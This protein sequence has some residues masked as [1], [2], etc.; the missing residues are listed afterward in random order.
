MLRLKQRVKQE[1]RVAEIRSRKGTGRLKETELPTHGR[2]KDVG[3][4]SLVPNLSGSQSRRERTL[5]KSARKCEMVEGVNRHCSSPWVPVVGKTGIPLMPTRVRRA[6]QLVQKGKAVVG[7]KA[8]IF[9]LRLKEREDGEVQLVGMGIDT[10]SKREGFTVMSAKHTFLNILSDAVTDVKE[11]VETR[12]IMRRARR[13]RKTPCRQNR[14]NRSRGGI[15]P[16][17]YARCNAKLR[18]R[19]IIASLFPIQICVVEDI[20]AKTM[21][22][23]K[24]W[25]KSFSPMEVGKKWFYGELTKMGTL[26]L[27]QGWETKAL[28]DALGLVK[29]KGKME[30]KFSAH[31][32]DSWVLAY[33]AVGG[34]KN[35]DNEVVYRMAPLRLHRR[36]LHVL[37][38]KSGVRKS[39][40]GTM[41]D[42]I[43]RGTVVE[44]QTW[45]VCL[46]GGYSEKTGISLH[47][48]ETGE[49]ICRNAK[50]EDFKMLRRSSWR[51]WK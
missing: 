37:Q 46:V 12:M 23:G 3:D 20:Q 31:C 43:K 2:V 38:P 51:Y 21:K 1:T 19:K 5:K 36:Q 11:R 9:Y 40:G 15:P 44:H 14:E 17:T 24:R 39:Y 6:R 22:G 34:N 7:C 41:S 29:T 49:R 8:G 26:V 30:E 13:N 33:S 4:T 47:S 48:V 45:G 32:V 28:R 35:P 50:K 16:S 25:N 42:G 27:K 10:G 18:I